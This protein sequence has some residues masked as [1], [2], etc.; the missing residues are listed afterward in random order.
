VR[1]RIRPI[2]LAAVTLILILPVMAAPAQAA[3][4]VTA[5]LGRRL[6]EVNLESGATVQCSAQGQLLDTN[7]NGLSDSLR[8]RAAC[9]EIR[10]T[11]RLRIYSVRVQSDFAD[12][13]AT[14]LV[15]G[16]DAVSASQPS[17]VVSYTPSSRF[18]P[19][20]GNFN[21]TYRVRQSFA[22]RSNDGS[23]AAFAMNSYQFQAR[24]I[25]AAQNDVC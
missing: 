5:N 20:P 13:W 14:A 10:G 16:T 17:Y 21:L 25:D 6:I 9:K 18:C 22:I 15:N 24:A 11:A 4:V 2:I 12:T 1:R 7:G 19:P 23:L 8:G 3:P